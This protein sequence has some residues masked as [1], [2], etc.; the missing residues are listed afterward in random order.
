MVAPLRDFNVGRMRGGEP[1][2]RGIEVRNEEG[3][4]GDKVERLPVVVVK[5]RRR[6]EEP[7]DD[8]SKRLIPGQ[9]R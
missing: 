1:E 6:C 4:A 8:F 3:I 5:G 9:G 2:P 7:F